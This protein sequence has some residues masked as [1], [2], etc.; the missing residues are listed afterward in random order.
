M[1]TVQGQFTY[2][3]D[4]LNNTYENCDKNGQIVRSQ[5]L[6]SFVSDFEERAKFLLDILVN[7]GYRTDLLRREFSKSVEKYISEFQR[8]TIPVNF[9]SWF[10]RISLNNFTEQ[11]NDN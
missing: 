4:V 2:F 8:W 6:C 11:G 1:L 10:D 7:R 9:S 3:Q 5:R